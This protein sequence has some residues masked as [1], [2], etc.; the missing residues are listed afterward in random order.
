MFAFGVC[1]GD[2]NKYQVYARVGILGVSEP[3]SVVIEL[4]DQVSIHAA[5]NA[6]LDNVR[7][8]AG[9][10]GLIL[11]HDDLEIKDRDL[12]T[13]L[14]A[15]FSDPEIAIVGAI[16]AVGVTTLS[17]WIG[18]KRG[19]LSESRFTVDHVD[20][21]RDV[22]MVDGSFICM[23]PWGVETLKFD[24][25]NYD[26]FHGYDADICFAARAKGRRVVWDVFDLF[27]HTKGNLG[28]NTSYIKNN[29]AFREK[30]I[31]SEPNDRFAFI[32]EQR[33][34][35]TLIEIGGGLKC[36][37]G[38][39][40]LDSE[41]GQGLWRRQAQ[42]TPWPISDNSADLAFASHVFEHIPAGRERIATM[43]EAWRVLKP[44]GSLE[45]RVPKFPTWQAIADPTHVSF[46][47]DQSFLYFTGYLA[48]DAEYG[49]KRWVLASLACYDEW[50]LRAILV[51]PALT[52]TNEY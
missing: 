6:I 24:E 33:S 50:E 38:W 26:G 30:W 16:G 20:T 19:V 25:A 4:R 31:L 2:D 10:E 45:I 44:G 46:W 49:M 39:I 17:W 22:D 32:D 1:V 5:Y 48:P 51:K 15:I 18:E 52:E 41:H 27:H 13:K 36:R 28:N 9:L 3:D 12:L 29:D 34:A 37:D 43:N 47:V 42:D 8:M 11:L 7:G 21:P 14:R 35:P 23:S 40:N